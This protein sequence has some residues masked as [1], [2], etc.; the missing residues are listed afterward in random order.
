MPQKTYLGCLNLQ[1][2][3]LPGKLQAPLIYCEGGFPYLVNHF[4]FIETSNF[5]NP[6]FHLKVSLKF[7]AIAGIL[8]T[9]VR[10]D[11]KNEDIL[12]DPV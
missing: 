4:D 1:V 5:S 8:S 7:P 12:I 10:R 2:I 3:L 11:Q 9:N 6:P